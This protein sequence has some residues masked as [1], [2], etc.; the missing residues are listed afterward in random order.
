MEILEM[1]SI[2][3]ELKITNK[4]KNSLVELNSRFEMTEDSVN[5]G[6]VSIEITNSKE[7]K[8]KN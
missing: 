6:V 1:K 5:L 2:I 7:Q 4:I 3:Q 8:K